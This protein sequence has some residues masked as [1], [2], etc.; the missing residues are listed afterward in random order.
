MYTHIYIYI[1]GPPRPSKC[2]HT[3]KYI[4]PQA[5]ATS[6]YKNR[7]TSLSKLYTNTI[8]GPLSHP[9]LPL[10]QEEVVAH[11]YLPQAQWS[12]SH[13]GE[14]SCSCACMDPYHMVAAGPTK[15][16]RNS[17]YDPVPTLPKNWKPIAMQDVQ[18]TNLKL[19]RVDRVPRAL[20]ITQSPLNLLENSL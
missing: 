8:R 12:T 10:P 1:Y 4:G 19:A 17:S 9:Q 6:W 18:T 13:G 2:L 11:P 20:G 7:L 14:H 5:R 3:Q 16:P 15:P